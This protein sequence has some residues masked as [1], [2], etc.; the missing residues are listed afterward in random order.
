[1]AI[2]SNES[3]LIDATITRVQKLE[4]QFEKL[5]NK[6][7]TQDQY[8]PGSIKTR[9]MGESNLY[10]YSG[11]AADRPT[12]GNIVTNSTSIY[13]STDTGILAIWNGT[14]WKTVTLT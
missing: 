11:L 8:L 12:A 1:M 6:R 5:S 2:P 13:F 14:A 3:N 7:I 10:V 9:A 4:Q